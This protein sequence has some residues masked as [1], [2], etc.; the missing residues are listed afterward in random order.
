MRKTAFMSDAAM[1]IPTAMGFML[2]P[3]SRY[4]LVSCCFLPDQAKK[5]P[6]PSDRASEQANTT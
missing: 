3:P 1:L 5:K 2:L 4:S 6:I